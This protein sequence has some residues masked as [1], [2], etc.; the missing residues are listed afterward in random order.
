M[1]EN[2]S[3]KLPRMYYLKDSEPFQIEKADVTSIDPEDPMLGQDYRENES[4]E[5]TGLISKL[6]KKKAPSKG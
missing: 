4:V 5:T 1:A 6:R 3:K 2:K